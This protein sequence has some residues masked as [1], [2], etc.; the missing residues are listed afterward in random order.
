MEPQSAKIPISTSM[1]AKNQQMQSAR[2]QV[3]QKTR[4]SNGKSP[5][6]LGSFAQALG[7]M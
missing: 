1:M 3:P 7:Y 2:G 6:E 4:R 5:S